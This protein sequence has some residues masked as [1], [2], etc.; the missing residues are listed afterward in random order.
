MAFKSKKKFEYKSRTAEQ[1]KA[2]ATG[3]NR[4]GFL[5]DG[6]KT[7]SPKAG[8]HTVRILPPTWD[9]AE[10]YGYDAYAHYNIGPDGGAYL[11]LQKMKEEECAICTDRLRAAKADDEELEN[12]LKPR[13][14]V[15]C[16]VIDRDNEKDGVLMWLMPWGLD[17]EITQQ[18]IDKKTG[19]LYELDNPEEGYDVS[20]ERQGEGLTTKYAG[21]QLDRRS[22]PLADDKDTSDEWLAFVAENPIPDQ[23]VFQDEDYLEKLVGEGLSAP[24]NSRDKAKGKEKEEKTTK[25]DRARLN[26]KDKEEEP[27]DKKKGGKEKEEV[28]EIDLDALTWESVHEMEEADLTALAEQ[29]E[30]DISDCDNEAAAADMLCEELKIEAPKKTSARV[31]LL[32]KKLGK[33]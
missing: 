6:V 28:E 22:S 13:Q 24:K 18:S 20:F 25:P 14:R 12:A 1:A 26:R 2:R 7:F 8:S 16:W 29:I 23:L 19:E 10:H 11:C 17:K 30:V 27:K 21:V 32:K 33:K 3:G 9:D 4:E 31:G 5:A 15:C